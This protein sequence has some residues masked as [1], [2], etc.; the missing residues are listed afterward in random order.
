MVWA[1]VASGYEHSVANMFF[2]PAGIFADGGATEGLNWIGFLV[3]N[4]IPVTLGNIA[5]GGLF[6]AGFYYFAL[7]GKE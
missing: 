2:V 3:N 7:K 5:G 1:F 6:V 4:L